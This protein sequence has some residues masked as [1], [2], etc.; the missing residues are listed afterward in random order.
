MD[1]N[2]MRFVG[3]SGP[4]RNERIYLHHSGIVRR[5]FVGIAYSFPFHIVQPVSEIGH[6]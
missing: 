4:V 3:M 2:P 5:R 6:L 1:A